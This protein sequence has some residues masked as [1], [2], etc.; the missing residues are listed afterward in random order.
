MGSSSSTA[1]QEEKAETPAAAQDNCG[2][3]EQQEALA[4]DVAEEPPV[5]RDLV[6]QQCSQTEV[7]PL[8]DEGTTAG[9]NELERR[10]EEKPPT[11]DKN[12]TEEHRA[13]AVELTIC[14]DETAET[15][16]QQQQHDHGEE[17]PCTPT[18]SP[19]GSSRRRGI[20]RLRADDDVRTSREKVK[21][22][23]KKA[24]SDEKNVEPPGSTTSSPQG[25]KEGRVARRLPLDADD[26]KDE[27][28]EMSE[29]EIEEP[30]GPPKPSKLRRVKQLEPEMAANIERDTGAKINGD[31][32]RIVLH[33]RGSKLSKETRLL[34][35]AVADSYLFEEPI[36][37]ET[38]ASRRDCCQGRTTDTGD[39]DEYADDDF[40]DFDEDSD[41]ATAETEVQAQVD[42]FHGEAKDSSTS[43]SF[44]EA[45]LRFFRA[46]PRQS[47]LAKKLGA[48]PVLHVK[49]S[50]SD[51]VCQEME[52]VGV[53]QRQYYSE[54]SRP[55]DAIAKNLN[56]SLLKVA[57]DFCFHPSRSR[58]SKERLVLR[59]CSTTEE[60][61]KH[62][63]ELLPP[64][65]EEVRRANDTIKHVTIQ[66]GTPT[67]KDAD[68]AGPGTA[69]RRS[70]MLV[71]DEGCLKVA[72]SATT[73]A[74][75]LAKDA[76]KGFAK[77]FLKTDKAK[78][79]GISTHE[80]RPSAPHGG[81]QSA[82]SSGILSAEGEDLEK[83]IDALLQKAEQEE[84]GKGDQQEESIAAAD[85][86][87]GAASSSSLPAGWTPG[88][89]ASEDQRGADMQVGLPEELRQFTHQAKSGLPPK[90]ALR[91]RQEILEEDDGEATPSLSELAN[92][93]FGDGLDG[94]DA[95]ALEGAAAGDLE[96]DEEEL[97]N[98]DARTDSTKTPSPKAASSRG[99]SRMS[100]RS[101][102]ATEDG[103]VEDLAA[104]DDAGEVPAEP[105]AAGFRLLQQRKKERQRQRQEA[106]GAAGRTIK[107]ESEDLMKLWMKQR[108]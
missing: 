87:S 30:L 107:D 82:D 97:A 84:E 17:W 28:A 34:L 63:G 105:Q 95:V 19:N 25:A 12:S 21:S 104:P 6:V 32:F 36:Q 98:D 103:T 88:C 37:E 22:D 10:Q 94:G 4:K 26:E 96:A 58:F 72:K 44:V 100:E 53:H 31:V 50:T 15:E 39:D 60:A 83:R 101:E 42:A 78:K 41:E 35:V 64:M 62:R 9:Q 68:L 90:E 55:S 81:T 89:A 91:A 80:D 74:A 27:G 1:E 54:G 48:V 61:L 71:M 20:D 57:L 46:K 102:P 16:E 99:G 18:T 5:E 2:V 13:P 85:V 66:Y 52:F 65:I 3:R 7:R 77:G 47:G 8:E 75:P 70:S 79:K 23:E 69:K 49:L 33:N 38:L 24:M 92:R 45:E 86:V 56:E 76:F 73:T 108:W 59:E 29:H 93:L 14:P 67:A 11:E 106:P 51:G 40:E 43:N